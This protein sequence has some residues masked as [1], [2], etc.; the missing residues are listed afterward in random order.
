MRLI[1]C[2]PALSVFILIRSGTRLLRLS[3]T[4]QIRYVDE[5]SPGAGPETIALFRGYSRIM[6]CRC[7]ASLKVKN[8]A[9]TEAL[10]QSWSF[11]WPFFLKPSI[12]GMCR[13]LP[14]WAC[15]LASLV[16]FEKR[17]GLLLMRYFRL[18][19]LGFPRSRSLFT[20]LES[21]PRGHTLRFRNPFSN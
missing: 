21:Q 20:V 10:V 15:W 7:A 2:L 4:R 13:V 19:G 6:V 16:G 9:G 1:A 18:V 17:P 11:F 12:L 14:W 5:S 3:Y 8:K